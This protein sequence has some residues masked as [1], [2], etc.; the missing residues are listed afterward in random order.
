MPNSMPAPTNSPVTCARGIDTGAHVGILMHRSLDLPV[1]IL[2]VL[3]AGAAYVPLDPDYPSERL[4]YILDDAGAVLVLSDAA[5]AP[6]AAAADVPALCLDT[7]WEGI[8][9]CP[10]APPDIKLPPGA[11]GYLIYTSGSTGRPKGCQLSH[12]N[13]AS[14]LDWAGR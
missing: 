1:A 7:E 9:R 10:A 13:L 2:G 5:L 8:A 4:A 3:K 11:P 14:Y 12:D 6:L